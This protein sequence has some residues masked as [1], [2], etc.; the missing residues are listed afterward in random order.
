MLGRTAL[1]PLLLALAQRT[2]AFHLIPDLESSIVED[3]YGP[4]PDFTTFS[5]DGSQ[6]GKRRV[7]VNSLRPP[8]AAVAFPLTSRDWPRLTQHV[9]SSSA[10]LPNDPRARIHQPPSSHIQPDPVRTRSSERHRRRI[11]VAS[12]ESPL[13]TSPR[14]HQTISCAAE[15]RA[16]PGSAR[17][18]RRVPGNRHSVP[19]A[20]G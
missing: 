6:A 1:H 15:K 11:S 18:R 17:A 2:S 16:G 5:S 20:G 8:P 3:G 4:N 7:I 10:P 12:V 19:A 13:P 9:S 14:K